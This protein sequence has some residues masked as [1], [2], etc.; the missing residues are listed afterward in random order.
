[1]MAQRGDFRQYHEPFSDLAAGHPPVLDGEPCVTPEAVL[2]RLGETAVRTP[3]FF[4]DTTEYRHVELFD[5]LPL[6]QDVT[7]TFI[8]RNPARSIESH[9]AMNPAVTRPE[10]GFEHQYEIFRR[11]REETGRTPVV[12][13]AD[14]LVE[15]PAET[16]RAYCD[17]VGIAYDDG[18]LTWASGERSEWS[19][20]SRWH[21]DVADSSGFRPSS[22][23]YDVT[24]ENDETL[25]A[26]HR[27]HLPFY[28]ELRACALVLP[29]AAG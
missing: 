15:R 18:A 8:I 1:M 2:R 19:R 6:A 25:A 14:V 11:V 3:V 16:V 20:T 12:V 27:H 28:E 29:A 4:K 22:K 13:D 5:V 21:Q 10:I 24:V 23:Q 9:Y 26:H 17:A 7:H